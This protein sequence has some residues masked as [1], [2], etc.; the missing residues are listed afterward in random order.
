MEGVGT[1]GLG[2]EGF[3]GLGCRGLGVLGFRG[4]SAFVVRIFH[5]STLRY[6]NQAKLWSE[7]GN[8]SDPKSFA[9]EV[10]WY[11]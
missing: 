9:R 2:E 8:I 5:G 6:T 10:N 1:R 3:K 11:G 7:Y 4:K